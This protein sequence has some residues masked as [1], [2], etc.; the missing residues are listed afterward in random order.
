MTWLRLDDS[1]YEHPKVVGLTD[2]AF[3]LH[4]RGL[5]YCSRLTTDGFITDALMR[6]TFPRA[7]QQTK[8]LVSARLWTREQGGYRIHDFLKYNPSREEVESKREIARRIR[9]EGGKARASSAVRIDGRFAPHDY[10]Q[11]ASSPAEYAN[12]PRPVPIPKGYVPVS[13]EDAG[14]R[15]GGMRQIGEAVRRIQGDAS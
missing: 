1:F 6:Q 12:Q 3:R 9:V 13:Q 7:A 11:N 2:A 10:Q 15:R 4:V 5:C 14:V 8:E